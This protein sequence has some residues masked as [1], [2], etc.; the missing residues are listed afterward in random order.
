MKNNIKSVTPKTL[1]DT[2][3]KIIDEEQSEL[4]SKTCLEYL[5]N[6]KNKKQKDNSVLYESAMEKALD[7]RLSCGW[8]GFYFSDKEFAKQLEEL[9]RDAGVGSPF[10]SVEVGPHDVVTPY[11]IS[12]YGVEPYSFRTQSVNLKGVY[13]HQVLLRLKDVFPE[14]EPI[15]VIVY[16]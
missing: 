11:S 4:T 9:V 5:G 8:V 1:L 14:L 16:D 6:V 10:S 12:L 2:L 3:R 15:K 7:E 13:M